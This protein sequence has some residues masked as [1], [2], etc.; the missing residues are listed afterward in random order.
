MEHQ[1]KAVILRTSDYGEADRLVSFFADNF[2]KAKGVA[3][4]AKRNSQ[5][6]LL[7]GRWQLPLKNWRRFTSPWKLRKKCCRPL[8]FRCR[9]LNCCSGG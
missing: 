7:S 6:R 9:V 3:K 2:G 5:W 1:S 4:N 8:L